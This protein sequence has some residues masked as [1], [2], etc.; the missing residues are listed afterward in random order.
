MENNTFLVFSFSSTKFAIASEAAVSE[1]EARLIPI[2]PE[3]SAGCGLA[4]KA[5]ID[6]KEK[7][8]ELLQKANIEHEG[9]YILNIK[10]KK[11]TAVKI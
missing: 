3:I 6:D 11:R 1:I 2:P 10:D 7:I 9:I 8:L 5:N 4:L